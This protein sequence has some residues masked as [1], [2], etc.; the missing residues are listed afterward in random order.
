MFIVKGAFG[1][2]LWKGKA[3]SANDAMKIAM[4]KGVWPWRIETVEKVK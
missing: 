1:V 2:V 4:D 3:R